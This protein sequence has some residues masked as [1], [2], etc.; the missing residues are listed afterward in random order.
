[1]V[2]L[3]EVVVCS[4]RRGAVSHRTLTIVYCFWRGRHVRLTYIWPILLLTVLKWCK[5]SRPKRTCELGRTLYALPRHKIL[6]CD[7]ILTREHSWSRRIPL[8]IGLDGLI[9]GCGKSLWLLRCRDAVDDVATVGE[10]RILVVI[11][12]LRVLSIFDIVLQGT[13][14]EAHEL[15]TLGQGIVVRRGCRSDMVQGVGGLCW[16][17]LCPERVA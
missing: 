16:K 13:R 8:L 3:D 7:G 10:L 14:L 6:W 9:L 12:P 2:C 15:G 5:L 4:I 1:M 17:C 11:D